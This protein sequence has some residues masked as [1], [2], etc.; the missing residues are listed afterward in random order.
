[1]PKKID[2]NEEQ[3]SATGY[4]K[5][6]VIADQ[7]TILFKILNSISVDQNNKLAINRENLQDLFISSFNTKI[8]LEVFKSGNFDLEDF[9]HYLDKISLLIALFSNKQML[10]SNPLTN[11]ISYEKVLQYRIALLSK[12]K[13]IYP[14]LNYYESISISKE[15]DKDNVILLEALK[16]FEIFD[17]RS[18]YSIIFEANKEGYEYF[19]TFIDFFKSFVYL[20]KSSIKMLFSTL[21]ILGLQDDFKLAIQKLQNKDHLEF[22]QLFS[23]LIIN[24]QK[25]A[26]SLKELQNKLLDYINS[27]VEDFNLKDKYLIVLEILKYKD[28]TNEFSRICSK[29]SYVPNLKYSVQSELEELEKNKIFES[30]EDFKNQFS[31]YEN[32]F[33]NDYLLKNTLDDIKTLLSET[34]HFLS[35]QYDGLRK[36]TTLLFKFLHSISIAPY[37]NFE[38]IDHIYNRQKY[39]DIDFTLDNLYESEL[40]LESLF[41][42]TYFGF[43]IVSLYYV[44]SNFSKSFKNVKFDFINDMYDLNLNNEYYVLSLC[45]DSNYINII[46]NVYDNVKNIKTN[47][48]NIEKLKELILMCLDTKSIVKYLDDFI[49]ENNFYVED[50]TNSEDLIQSIEK[51]QK[52]FYNSYPRIVQFLEFL[53]FTKYFELSDTL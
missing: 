7:N 3:F 40:F 24:S 1:M 12:V 20:D 29:Y 10:E 9:E 15:K 36:N 45:K 43:V 38:I 25:L 5:P 14:D 11:H 32:L 53:K 28:L 37:A 16:E 42:N 4:Q 26:N 33:Y 22:Y 18:S 51:F 41:L 6:N 8:L 30:I 49:N 35:Y 46:K 34:R 19:K 2:N 23:N 48:S 21:Y 39:K 27:N 13:S 31:Q 50:Q 52:D 47:N 44:F 17:S